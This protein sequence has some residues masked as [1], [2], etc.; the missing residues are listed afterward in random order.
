MS[1]T[2]ELTPQQRE[3][4]LEGLRFVRSAR[5]YEFREASEPA[6]PR[7]DNDLRT[8]AELVTQL[9]PAAGSARPSNTPR[10]VS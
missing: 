5:R 4:V 3:L 2:V 7:R 10:S 1:L 9:D 8:I 6:D